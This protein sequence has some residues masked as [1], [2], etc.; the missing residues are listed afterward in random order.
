MLEGRVGCTGVSV[1]AGVMIGSSGVSVGFGRIPGVTLGAGV[2]DGVSGSC[3]PLLDGVV[4]PFLSPS[5]F[6]FVF[7]LL[8]PAGIV[9]IIYHTAYVSVRQVLLQDHGRGYG[10]LFSVYLDNFISVRDKQLVIVV[11]IKC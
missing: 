9:L 3:V 5:V 8:F 1:G 2:T 7:P 10:F 6:P 4:V 11:Q